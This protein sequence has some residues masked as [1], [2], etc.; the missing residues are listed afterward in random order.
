MSSITFAGVELGGTKTICSIGDAK[1][2]VMDRLT[3]A[4]STPEETLAPIV[5][6]I[7]SYAVD[8]VGL[9]SF[10]PLNVDARDEQ[11]GRFYAT[12]KPDWSGF[13]MGRY[14][15]NH[16][17]C[18]VSI[19]TDVAAAGLAEHQLG[20]GQGLS[21]M[22]YIT[23][24]TGIG[25]AAIIDG[26]PVMGLSHP[27]MGH[28]SLL[29]VDGDESF[30]SVCPYHSHCAEGLASGAAIFKRWGEPLNH[31]DPLHSA[32]AYQSQYLAQFIHALTLLYSPQK[33]VIGGGVSSERLLETVRQELLP[34]FNGYVPGLESMEALQRYVCLP[35]LAG[36]AG[37]MGSLLVAARAIAEIQES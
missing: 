22:A 24:G 12:P 33:I 17:D 13:E 14:F 26:K 20:A 32:W 35:A 27:E 10:G 25:A 37:P 3:V 1:T 28:L 34:I 23:I 8:A 21:N 9:A 4:T 11:Y 19:E 15:Q 31:F 36:D 16:F 5:E 6:F 30:E 7:A 2:G 18:P 29:R